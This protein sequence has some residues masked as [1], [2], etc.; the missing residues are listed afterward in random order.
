VNVS[1]KI[2]QPRF[3]SRDEILSLHEGSLH[4][5][6]GVH[7]VLDE[8]KL[9]SAMAMP[10][11]GFGKDLAHAFP[12]G[13]AAAYGFYLAMNHAFRDGNKR[14]AFAA[15][16]AFLHMNGWRFALPDDEAA[17][18]ILEVI[19]EH[20]DKTWLE[21]RVERHSHERASWELR[22]FLQA[23]TFGEIADVL[24]SGL[25]DPDLERAHEGRIVSMIEAARAIPLINQANLGANAAEQSREDL[26][27][28]QLRAMA[29]L[30]RAIHAIAEDLGYEW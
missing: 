2:G 30:L 4:A 17:A 9:D 20:R 22:D 13:I 25:T 5:Y 28:S 12:F 8:G 6:G 29:H 18:L 15:M 16:V 7:G 1:P 26:E 14:T 19:T 27:A 23:L 10:M 21:S 3:L 24:R 11:Q